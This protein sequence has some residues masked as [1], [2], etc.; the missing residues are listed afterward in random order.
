MPCQRRVRPG[1][2]APVSLL[3][4]TFSFGSMTLISRILGFV[5]DVVLARWF[6]A[7][8]A[9]DAFF[10]AF[11][12]PNFLRRLFAEGSFSLAFVPVL[13]EYRERGDPAALKSLIDATTGTLM[14]V[15][16][17]ITALGVAGAPWIVR[18]FAPGFVAD[19]EQLALATELLR[20]T[21]PYLLLIAL[22]ALAGGILNT[23]GRFALPALTPALLNVAMIVA[24]VAFSTHFDEPVK[25][26]AWGV[27]AAG[28]LQL[29]IQLPALARLGLLPRPRLGF[30]HAGVRRIMRLMV[31]TLFGS[32]V[33][34]INLL[35]DVLIASLL[36]SGSLSW[37]YYADRLMEFPLGLFGVALSTVILPSLAALH[38]RADYTRFR[39]TL[40]WAVLL[41]L[42]IGVPSAVGLAVLAQPLVTTLF[43]YGAFQPSDVHMAALALLAYCAGLPAFIGVKILAPAYFS[44][45]DTRTPVRVAVTA[46]VANMLLN[47]VFVLVLSWQLAGRDFSAGLL[48][49]LAA[50]PGAHVALALASS[51]SGWLNAVLLWRNLRRSGLAPVVP[52]KRLLQVAAASA[53]MAAAVLAMVPAAESWFAAGAAARAGW[54]AGLVVVGALV[55]ALAL[56]ALGLRP[57]HLARPAVVEGRDSGT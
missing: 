40:N 52:V 30:A 57:R 22:T 49:T 9:T 37:L 38:A 32:S 47:I 2:S 54:L 36:I 10:V 55:Y 51:V 23:F 39:A 31:P 29:T 44:R 16:L 48:A 27:F 20:I 5:R 46:L 53:L 34:Q 43:Q 1:E 26:L 25:A 41:G 3:R 7:S 42:T 33:A 6:G 11:K 56:L 18:V 13:A 19:P 50:N 14:A 45:Q 21:F 35:L 12:I 4:S 17:M 15:L 8:A 24:A 28:V